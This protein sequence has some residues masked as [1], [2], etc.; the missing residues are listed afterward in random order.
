VRLLLLLRC[1]HDEVTEF[2]SELFSRRPGTVPSFAPVPV[3]S[4]NQLSRFLQSETGWIAQNF[5]GFGE[6][7]S[8]V[9]GG[10]S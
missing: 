5:V 2:S 10:E 6:S 3:P 1:V 4:V 8:L 9:E 7:S